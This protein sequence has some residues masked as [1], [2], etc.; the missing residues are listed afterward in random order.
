MKN[1]MTYKGFIASMEFD[2]DDKILVG[3]ILTEKGSESFK[4][5]VI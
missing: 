4:K 3:E 2:P 1:Q 5:P